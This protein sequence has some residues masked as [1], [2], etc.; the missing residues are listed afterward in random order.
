MEDYTADCGMIKSRTND[1]SNY[2][3]RRL[4]NAAH[5]AKIQPIDTVFGDFGDA[6]GLKDAIT[7]A[8]GLGY[9]GKRCIHPKQVLSC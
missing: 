1:E 8:K 9:V 5:A 4:A 3:I 6:Q 7:F 2:A